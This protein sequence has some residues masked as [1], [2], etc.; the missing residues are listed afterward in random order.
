[1]LL[2]VVGARAA[3]GLASRR[4]A[5]VSLLDLLPTFADAPVPDDLP[6]ASLL[7]TVQSDTEV[8]PSRCVCA[9]YHGEGV[10]APYFMMLRDRLKYICVH[11]HEERLHDLDADSDELQNVVAMARYQ[12]R[13][14][15]MRAELLKTFDPDAIAVAAMTSQRNRS[16]LYD[17]C[18]SARQC[19]CA[20]SDR[21]ER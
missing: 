1:M 13:L 10:R 6:G 7:E 16:F 12:P 19:R 17:C 21:S 14:E 11:G 15:Q 20:A 8:D 9:E 5:P 18:S 4:A 3:V 2:R